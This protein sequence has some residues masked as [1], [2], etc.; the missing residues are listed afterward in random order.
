MDLQRD[1]GGLEARMDEH[2]KRFDRLDKTITDGFKSVNARLDTITE[3]E[4]RR[5]GAMWLV[6]IILGS[7]GLIGAWEL[8]KGMIH[9]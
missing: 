5:K 9:Q 6:K 8:I 2:D 4:N 7:A 3:A 1:I